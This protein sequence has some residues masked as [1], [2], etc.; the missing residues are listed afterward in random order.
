MDE[1]VKSGITLEVCPTSNLK[2]MMVKDTRE[3]TRVIRRLADHGVSMTINTDGPELYDTNVFKE[4]QFL[5]KLGAMTRQEIA[6]CN[7]QAFAAS[8]IGNGTVKD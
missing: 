6:R 7:K 3:L 4:Q 2:N 5:L 1:L 8:F